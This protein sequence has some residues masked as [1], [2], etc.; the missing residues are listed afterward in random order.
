MELRGFEPLTPSM[1]TRASNRLLVDGELAAQG[2]D[3]ARHLNTVWAEDA[4]RQGHLPKADRHALVVSGL[5]IGL[6]RQ[7]A[8]RWPLLVP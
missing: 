6:A 8:Y 3:P 4:R 2:T 7:R 1:R 5:A